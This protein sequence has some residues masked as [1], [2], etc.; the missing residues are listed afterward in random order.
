M[1]CFF[2]F[3]DPGRDEKF[4]LHGVDKDDFERIVQN[5]AK[6]ESSRSSDRYI[7]FGYSLDGRWT[8]C[9]YEML[10]EDTILPITAYFP[11]ED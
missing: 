8:A 3:W 7:A 9:V 10:D 11:G 4:D 6:V 1:P 2:F 5:A